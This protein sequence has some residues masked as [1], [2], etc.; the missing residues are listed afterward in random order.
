M[1][2]AVVHDGDAQ[3]KEHHCK[4]AQ[5]FLASWAH[6]PAK[7]SRQFAALNAESLSTT[8]ISHTVSF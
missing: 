6:K 4:T 1:N 8:S 2:A 3:D 7:G 5:L